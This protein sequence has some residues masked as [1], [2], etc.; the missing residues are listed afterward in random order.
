MYLVRVAPLAVD[1]LYRHAWRTYFRSI[2]TA[3]AARYSVRHSGG[4]VGKRPLGRPKLRATWSTPEGGD[5]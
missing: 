3:A 4:G 1:L 2:A 5:Q